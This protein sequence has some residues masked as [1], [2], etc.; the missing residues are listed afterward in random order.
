M[1]APVGVVNSVCG[2]AL[3]IGWPWSRA[4]VAGAGTGR[5]PC[6]VSTVPLPTLMR[7]Q[8]T[9][10]TSSDQRDASAD[11]IADG[12]NRADFMEVDF[13]N[14][15]IM[16][17]RFGFGQTLKD[18][19]GVGFGSGRQ[20]PALDDLFDV[21]QVAVLLLLGEIDAKFGG[22]HA[23]ALGFGETKC[24][25]ELQALKR[26][27]DGWPIRA[28]IEQSA[29]SHIAADARKDVEIAKEHGSTSVARKG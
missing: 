24:G 9:S 15:H 18:G 8:W 21:R 29:D 16:R 12:I 27:F 5:V 23:L 10:E 4:D 28:G 1:A 7:E 22:G 26:G 19:E 11:D 3:Y 25:V 13:F 14:G 20:F 17:F 6:S 2:P